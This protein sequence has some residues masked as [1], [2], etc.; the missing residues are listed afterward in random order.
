MC[1]DDA[2]DAVGIL[3]L[4]SSLVDKSMLRLDETSPSMRVV[5]PETIRQFAMDK[6]IGLP[7]LPA[8]RDRHA[9]WFAA[10]DGPLVVG[11]WELTRS[12]RFALGRADQDN[13]AVALDWATGTGGADALR[14]IRIL[15]GLH[16]ELREPADFGNRIR[17]A[18]SAAPD[19]PASLRAVALARLGWEILET[20]PGRSDAAIE[21]SMQALAL[22]REC[23]DL[24][25]MA[26]VAMWSG[27]TARDSA[28]ATE[29]G[30]E[31][32]AAADAT[33]DTE[34]A[35]YV[36]LEVVKLSEVDACEVLLEDADRLARRDGLDGYRA[37][38]AYWIAQLASHRGDEALALRSM[39]EA[40]A[41]DAAAPT[42]D[43]WGS[44]TWG[45]IV[46][47]DQGHFVEA[48][49][50]LADALH[51]L[52]RVPT[53]LHESETRA[54]CAHLARL[55]GDAAA[56]RTEADAALGPRR[57]YLRWTDG[58]ALLALAS[59]DRLDG[60][61][62]TAVSS[63]LPILV[64]SGRVTDVA[65]QAMEELAACLADLGQ[66]DDA[67]RA[68]ATADDW[69]RAERAPLPPGRRP[70]VEHLRAQLD[71]AAPMT[72]EQLLELAR[73]AAVL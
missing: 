46:L 35:V 53:G 68:L 60:E 3:E 61:P 30:R 13:L 20:D 39:D 49:A 55:R 34:L 70:P 63:L 9:A 1:A 15:A 72:H 37:A 25:T 54:G 19:A 69:R 23:G 21:A 65:A 31:A 33:G 11:P 40:L 38:I 57:P 36:R 62:A 67:A 58:L 8:L 71:P 51:L 22:A 64:D 24:R 45:A 59:A 28:Q 16:P 73:V 12:E 2:I 6:L 4:I 5:L 29:I 52:G 41:F 26:E 27:F 42:A 32:V 43:R 18:L 10:L 56:A 14:V 48:E 17:A 44:R 66:P 7:E 50:L 47:A